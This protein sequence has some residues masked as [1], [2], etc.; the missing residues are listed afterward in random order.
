MT[1][2]DYAVLIGALFALIGPFLIGFIGAIIFNKINN[3]DQPNP[4][5]CG[6]IWAMIAILLFHKNDE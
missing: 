3:D 5:L 6:F 2:V 1:D 4:F